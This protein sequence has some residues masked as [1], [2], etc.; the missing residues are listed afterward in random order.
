MEFLKDSVSRE[1]GLSEDMV[2]IEGSENERAKSPLRIKYEAEKSVLRQKLG[3]LE[4]IRQK[5]GLTQRKMTQL[6]LVDPSAWTRW[7][8]DESRVPPHVYR[9]LQWYLELVDKK[10]EWSPHNSFQPYLQTQVPRLDQQIVELQIQLEKA[11]QTSQ[12]QSRAFQ[13]AM[14][15]AQN[16][17]QAEKHTL[18]SKIEKKDMSLAAWK[19]IVLLHSCALFASLVW[20]LLS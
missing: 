19:L 11:I 5:L 18:E 8:R 16:Q 1:G 4:E 10:P 6:L 9:S 14:R 13:E 3:S 15:E 12:S 2:F 7:M 20:W 17:W